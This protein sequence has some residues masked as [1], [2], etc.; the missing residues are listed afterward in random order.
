MPSS[1][2]PPSIGGGRMDWGA[3]ALAAPTTPGR[4]L[5]V[6]DRDKVDP[7]LRQA[8]E[9]MEA[10]FLNYMMKVMRETVP[11]NDMDLESPATAIYRGMQDSEYAQKAAHNGGIGLAD[12]LIAYLEGQRYNLPGGQGVPTVTTDK[13][14]GTGG[15]HEG[16]SNRK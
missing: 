10:M 13:V 14:S 6:V 12:Q 1:L 7:G 15:T 3:N 5:P 16:R 8:A 11:K 2:T 9:G 4:R